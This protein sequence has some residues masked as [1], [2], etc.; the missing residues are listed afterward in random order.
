MNSVPHLPIRH[1]LT[2]TGPVRFISNLAVLYA[3]IQPWKLAVVDSKSRETEAMVPCG[4]SAVRYST[5]MNMQI[6]RMLVG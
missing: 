1:T 3:L 6:E 2:D 4:Q 5:Q